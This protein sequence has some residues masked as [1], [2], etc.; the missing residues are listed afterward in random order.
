MLLQTNGP[1][2]SSTCFVHCT[3]QAALACVLYYSVL[4]TN[5]P[6]KHIDVGLGDMCVALC[7]LH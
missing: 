7:R 6:N 1:D 2:L 4:Q 5:G 3:L